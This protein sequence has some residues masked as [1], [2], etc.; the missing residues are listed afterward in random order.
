MESCKFQIDVLEERIAPAPSCPIP[1]NANALPPDN[2]G[3]TNAAGHIVDGP[4]AAA[5]ALDNWFGKAACD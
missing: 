1:A 2:P 4:E 3:T 5:V